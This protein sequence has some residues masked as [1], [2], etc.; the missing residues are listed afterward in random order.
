MGDSALLG[1]FPIAPFFYGHGQTSG[2]CSQSRS[3]CGL[4]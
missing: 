2:A 1:F 4:T 3:F